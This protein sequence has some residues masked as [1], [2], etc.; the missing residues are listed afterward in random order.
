MKTVESIE[1]FVTELKKIISECNQKE[2]K[3]FFRGETKIHGPSK[4]D[5]ADSIKESLKPSIYRKENWIKNEDRIFKEYI[6]RNPDEFTTE[7]TTFE[8]LVKMQH[9]SL[10]TRLL[11]ITTNALLSL[12]MACK[13]YHNEEDGYVIIFKI[14]HSKIKFY[15]SDTVSVVANI[16]RR[17]C[18][19]DNALDLTSLGDEK[20]DLEKFNKTIPISYLLHEI[21]DEKPYFYPIIKKEHISDVWCVRPLMKNRRIIRQ[22]GAFLLFGIDGSKTKCPSIP[23]DYIET[24]KINK[25]SKKGIIS[26][27]EIL[28]ISEDK[29]YPELDKVAEYLKTTLFS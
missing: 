14:P 19:G 5:L 9:Y 26:D 11:D 21:R 4:D 3:I 16:A 22:D 12:N 13:K 25:G 23:N 1:E 7:K 10:P 28:G 29:I 6:L 24:I 17:P 8:K 20:N 15:D 27:L 18:D 2:V